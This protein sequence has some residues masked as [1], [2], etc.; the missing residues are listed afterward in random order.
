MQVLIIEDEKPA[1]DKL[2]RSLERIDHE[3]EVLDTLGS[4]QQAVG[5]LKENRADLI[6]LDIHL[7]DG[8]SFKIFEQLQNAGIEYIQTPIIF[9]TAYDEYA[10]EAFKLNS[11]DYLLKPVN[12]RD[13]EASLQKYRHLQEQIPPLQ[14][15]FKS[16][17]D[18]LRK[19]AYKKRFMVSFGQRMKSIDTHQIAYFYAHDKLVQMLTFENQRYV[20]DHTIQQLD[21]ILDPEIFFRINRK[22]MVNIEAI[23]QMHSYSKSRV[24]LDLRPESTMEAVV[25]V[26]RSSDFKAWLD[27]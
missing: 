2:I 4:V 14:Q 23:E 11:I 18:S 21:E 3:I 12:R 26:E 16:L 8:V 6:F 13:L 20:V 17:I 25:S 9:T 15:N 1:A 24:K 7:S 10:I 5:W 27:R 22:F 19:P